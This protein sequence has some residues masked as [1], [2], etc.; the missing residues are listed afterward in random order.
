MNLVSCQLYVA[1]S[2]ITD[3]RVESDDEV[4]KL[5]KEINGYDRLRFCP[6]H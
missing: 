6:T 1:P 4:K 2:E 3:L 5:Q